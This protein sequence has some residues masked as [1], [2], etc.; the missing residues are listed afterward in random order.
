MPVNSSSEYSNKSQH[1]DIHNDESVK[2]LCLH[3][4]SE[5]VRLGREL[6]RDDDGERLTRYKARM[7]AEEVLLRKKYSEEM[8]FLQSE[9]SA[10]RDELLATQVA[11]EE[12]VR[13]VASASGSGQWQSRFHSNSSAGQPERLDV[14]TEDLLNYAQND[15]DDFDTLQQV[16]F[17]EDEIDKLVD[18]ENQSRSTRQFICILIRAYDDLKQISYRGHHVRLFRSSQFQYRIPIFRLERFRY[19]GSQQ[20]SRQRGADSKETECTSDASA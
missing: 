7:R 3:S 6:Q 16:L 15:E 13:S 1:V 4:F 11:Y 12:I 20:Q 10:L 9:L 8:E 17:M 14:L 2:K 5:G 18:D 19:A